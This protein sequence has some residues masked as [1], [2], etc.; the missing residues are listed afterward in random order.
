MSNFRHD[1]SAASGRLRVAGIFA[2]DIALVTHYVTPKGSIYAKRFYEVM[3]PVTA[4]QFTGSW[5]PP[6]KDVDIQYAAENQSTST[7]IAYVIELKNQ[8]K[9][10]LLVS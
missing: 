5:T 4:Q 2:G 8:D 3:N 7:S 9:P 6:I 10:D 1:A